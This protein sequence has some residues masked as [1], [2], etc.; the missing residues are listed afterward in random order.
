MADKPV[1]AVVIGDPGGIGP[2]VICKAMAAGDLYD[3]IRPVLI[4]SKEVVESAT[5]IAG[6]NF[7][8]RHVDSLDD[9][10][11]DPAILDVY[12]TGR[13]DAANL[14]YGE[15][16][17]ESGRAQADWLIE[18]D[19]LCR[20]GRTAGLLMGCV[21]TETLQ[22]ASAE[23]ELMKLAEPVPGKSYLLVVTGPLRV[24]HMIHH[25]PMREVCDLI[26]KETVLHAL[27]MTHDNFEQWGVEKP[28]IV[29]SG[30]NVHA[31]GQEDQQ[32]IAPG[33]EA[34]RAAGID[35]TGPVSPDTVYRQ[36]I[37]GQYDVVLAMSHDLSNLGEVRAAASTLLPGR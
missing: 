21:N 1:I 35:A 28:R 34:A 14:T 22:L 17:A 4:G 24:V 8:I 32:E 11:M 10:G 27:R 29:V 26:K 15:G 20:E 12:D 36:N 7:Q 6:A 5:K 23:E 16:S 18:A 9:A 2:E 13:F 30:W 19:T 3:A 25:Y 33:V 31:H 37:E